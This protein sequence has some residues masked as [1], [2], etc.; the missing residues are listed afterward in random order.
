MIWADRLG[1]V[2]ALI[3]VVALALVVETNN[4][5]ATFAAFAMPPWL[6]LRSLDFVLTGRIRLG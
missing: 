2:W 6:L 4:V 5:A 3:C 1:V